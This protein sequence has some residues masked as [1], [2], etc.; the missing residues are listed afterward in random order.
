MQH[1]ALT[2][3][4]R[5]LPFIVRLLRSITYPVEAGAGGAKGCPPLAAGKAGDEWRCPKETATRYLGLAAP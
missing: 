2:L 4:C 3:P 1:R 5:R